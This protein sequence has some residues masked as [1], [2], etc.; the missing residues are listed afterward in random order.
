MAS[1]HTRMRLNPARIVKCTTFKRGYATH[2]EAHA[3][4]ELTMQNEQVSPGCHIMPYLCDRCGEYHNANRRI[5]PANGR[6]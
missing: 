1:R 5:V 4:A 6:A 3:A 2:E